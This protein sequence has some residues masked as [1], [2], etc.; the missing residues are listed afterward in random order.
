MEADFPMSKTRVVIAGL[1]LIAVVALIAVPRGKAQGA[2]DENSKI[3]I[4]FAIMQAS[5]IPLS[6][7]GKNP[8]LVGLGSYIVNAHS[9]CN[10]CHGNPTY[11]AATDPFTGG[12]GAFDPNGYLV[13]GVPIFGPIFVPRNITPDK[14]GKPAGLSLDEFKHLIRTGQDPD[15]TGPPPDSPLLQVMP[16]PIFRNMTDRDLDAVYE[17]LSSIPCLPKKSARCGP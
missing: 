15:P 4:G 2:S 12:S 9:D 11:S 1:S 10:G 14:D 16:W 3:Q 7:K 17:F 6:F 8:S 13:G 5:G